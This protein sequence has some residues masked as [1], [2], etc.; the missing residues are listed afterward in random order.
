MTAPIAFLDAL[1]GAALRRV[2]AAASAHLRASAKA[3][4]AINVYPVPDGDT[5]SNMSATLREAV[6]RALSLDGEATVPEVLQAIAKGALYGARG[7]SGVILS[8]ALRGFAEGVGTTARLDGAS[9][10]NGL[11]QAA[12]QAYRAVSKPQEG[13]MLTVLRE[14][15]DAAM[16]EADT[17][18]GDGRGTGCAPVLAAAVRAADR[19]EAATIDQLPALKEAGVP[20]AGGEGVCVILRG[21]LAAIV[22]G[23]PEVR[24]HVTNRPI[25]LAAGHG[26]DAF[27][28]CTEFL[29][30]PVGSALEIGAMRTLAESGGNRSV[31][32]VGDGELLRVHAHS[33]EPQALLDAAEGLGRLS[34]VKVEDM[35]AQHSRFKD[36]G[37]G[38]GVKTGLLAMSRGDG[39]DEIFESLGAAVSDL[40]VVEKP[41]AG[42]I[43]DAADALRLADVIVLA[44][45]KNVLLAA[46]Q[47]REL[48]KATLHV[49]PTTTLP[50][51]IAAA[52][53]FDPAEPATL[54]AGEMLAAARQVRT[55]EVTIA[56]A[57]RTSEGIA[58]RAGEAI[59]LVDGTLAGTSA[60]AE[61]ALLTGL[62]HAGVSDGQLVTVYAGEGVGEA[63]CA[64]AASAVREQFPGAEVE[65]MRGGQPLYPY[66]A[67]VE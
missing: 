41:P 59:V 27:G 23:A 18:P 52:M 9:L 16:T 63:E 7:N 24:E 35:S 4:D 60:S 25:A 34:R 5:G 6:D 38:A 13:T 61:E 66:I 14:A 50:Q 37:S 21:L 15:G 17:L 48:T 64:R 57:S 67:S 2:F 62:R 36:T 28:F 58:V 51:G 31:V 32:V 1:D 46:E 19:A 42:Q 55:I 8:Q 20:D 54:N 45:H 29:I 47:A 43:A 30:E 33:L 11:R 65:A 26:D 44:N 3:V 39:F 12:Q 22:G 49:V 10:A 40:G 56:G 53:A